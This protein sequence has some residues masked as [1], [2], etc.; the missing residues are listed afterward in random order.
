MHSTNNFKKKARKSY[1]WNVPHKCTL[2]VY[3][4]QQACALYYHYARILIM[5]F[6]FCNIVLCFSHIRVWKV[7]NP[8]TCSFI[9][10]RCLQ[11]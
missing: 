6:I 10:S 4:A 11:P 7:F 2:H 9:L 8:T 1:L 3:K 5:I